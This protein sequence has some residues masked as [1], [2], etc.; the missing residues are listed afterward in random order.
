MSADV[1]K[2]IEQATAGLKDDPELCMD[3]QEEL[4]SHIRDAAEAFRS[5]GH[6]AEEGLNHGLKAFGPATELADDLLAAN[7]TRM[8]LRALVRLAVRALLVPLSVFVAIWVVADT[9]SGTAPMWGVFSS[10]V[11][12]GAPGPSRESDRLLGI[13]GLSDEER[14]VFHGDR[15]FETPTDRQKAIWERWPTN[16]M[17]YGNYIAALVSE[18][19]EDSDLES[20]ENE[21][22][23]GMALDP[24]NA[25]Y[26]YLLAGKMVRRACELEETPEK[27]HFTL[28]IKDRQLLDRA[29]TEFLAGTRKPYCN[30]YTGDMLTLRLSII[31]PARHMTEDLARIGIAAGVLLPAIAEYHN[32]AK[33]TGPYAEVLAAEGK[34]AKAIACLESWYPLSKHIFEKSFTLIEVLVGFA[35]VKCGERNADILES[36]GKEEK[37][38][39]MRECALV[40][41]SPEKAWRARRNQVRGQEESLRAHGSML[42]SLLL[43]AAG[44]TMS[45]HD[46]A[47]GRYLEH[48]LLERT[49]L[50]TY[51]LGFMIMMLVA[52][53]ASQPWRRARGGTA[54]SMLLL[55]DANRA[56]KILL[57]SVI[58]PLAVFFLYTRHSDLGG[59]SYSLLHWPRFIAELLLLA[60]VICYTSISMT[61]RTIR[62]RCLALGIAVPEPSRAL[63]RL[64]FSFIAIAMFV[65]LALCPVVLVPDIG[66]PWTQP[67]VVI[68]GGAVT[69]VLFLLLVICCLLSCFRGDDAFILFRLTVARSMVPLLASVAIIV[70]LLAQP[71]LNARE[72]RLVAIDG[73]GNGGF[74]DVETKVTQRLKADFEL[75]IQQAEKADERL[76]GTN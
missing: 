17:Y 63:R 18:F 59:R 38:A 70:G 22:R 16:R 58:V 24:Q 76:R 7:R 6:S 48:T 13:H 43:P 45:D 52:F 68:A 11:A 29:M 25:R 40:L 47:P 20:F 5:E 54:V 36:M 41:Q 1:S 49:A 61:S 53:L 46:L 2:V 10:L 34:H 50:L 66:M 39:R 60:F 73:L 19:G 31:P 56:A 55:P 65:L 37:A 35:A 62:C 32:L 51:M 28:N 64:L 72:A 67:L 42:H 75:A 30:S 3:V 4:K 57:L 74:T 26:N 69:V 27:A 8:K 14:L 9:Y 15:S 12:G 33:V 21:L 71:H 23:R 44:E